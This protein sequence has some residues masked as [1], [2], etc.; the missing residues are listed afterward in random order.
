[1]SRYLIVGYNDA[2]DESCVDY[3][4]DPPTP[5]PEMPAGLTPAVY[6]WEKVRLSQGF[7]LVAVWD[8]DELQ[9]TLGQLKSHTEA[10]LLDDFRQMTFDYAPSR[11]HAKAAE[12]EHAR[13]AEAR[14]R[15]ICPPGWEPYHTGG[16]LWVWERK[17]PDGA[18]LW[19]S[20]DGG[21]EPSAP[22]TPVMLG[23][24]TH[25]TD[26]GDVKTHENIAE[27]LSAAAQLERAHTPEVR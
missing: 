9:D 13:R 10:R 20:D 14:T 18:W 3:L 25:E 22:G 23:L 26:E 6:E 24:Y 8:E 15:L 21:G 16:G 17:L 1:M 11:L 2:E 27:A 7:T 12:A 4:A 19:L 5:D